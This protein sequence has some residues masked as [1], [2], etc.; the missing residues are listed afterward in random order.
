MAKKRYFSKL[1]IDK[2]A[3]GMAPLPEETGNVNRDAKIMNKWL[4]ENV[5]GPPAPALSKTDKLLNKMKTV[6]NALKRVSGWDHFEPEREAAKEAA[7]S[8]SGYDHFEPERET[9]KKM[10][11]GISGHEHF[12]KKDGDE[13]EE[14]E[15]KE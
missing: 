1:K 8:M 11:K 10:A 9:A 5:G 13:K 14:K 3:P 2:P 4:E 7:K 6:G 12:S 15:D